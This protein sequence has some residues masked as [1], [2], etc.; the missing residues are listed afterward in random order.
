MKYLTFIRSC[1]CLK[2]EQI[3]KDLWECGAVT[4]RMEG[5]FVL[6][7]EEECVKYHSV[8]PNSNKPKYQLLKC[9]KNAIRRDLNITKNPDITLI[10]P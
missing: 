8:A 9:K 1:T 2:S 3:F 4:K 5:K 7:E 10:H 6:S